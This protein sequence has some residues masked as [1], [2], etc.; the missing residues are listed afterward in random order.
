MHTRPNFLDS[1]AL[2]IFHELEECRPPDEVSE[3]KSETRSTIK[4]KP[5]Q[6]STLSIEHIPRH[7]PSISVWDG[8]P[9]LVGSVPSSIS[10]DRGALGCMINQIAIDRA[11]SVS[12]SRSNQYQHV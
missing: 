9:G 10:T 12:S 6:L 2:E 1:A 3:P 7:D 11:S 8:G 4:T 5:I